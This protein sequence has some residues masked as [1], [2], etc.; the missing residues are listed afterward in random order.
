MEKS[1][2]NETNS[3]CI[4][5]LQYGGGYSVWRR[6]TINKVEDIQYR[7]VTPS[8]W[9]RRIISTV[10]GMQDGPVTSSI[11]RRVCST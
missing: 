2:L 5:F 6:H 1:H 8:V 9:R 3:P 11:M 7:C 4:N 10:E